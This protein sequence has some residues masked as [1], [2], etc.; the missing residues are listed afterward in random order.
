MT[1]SLN[2]R[3]DLSVLI[4]HPDNSWD[5]GWCCKFQCIPVPVVQLRA[6]IEHDFS[7]QAWSINDQPGQ[8]S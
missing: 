6:R 4:S 2:F 3:D 7:D 8:L 5:R 1:S